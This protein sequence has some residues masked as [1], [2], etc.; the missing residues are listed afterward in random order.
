M[1][2][3]KLSKRT[4]L[5][6]FAFVMMLNA[7]LAIF[8]LRTVLAQTSDKKFR[9]QPPI[10]AEVVRQDDSPLTVT[11]INVDNTAES[12]QTVNYAA[13]N[14]GLKKI[15]AYV[16]LYADESGV[17]GAS[18]KFFQAFSSGQTIQSS[19]SKGRLNIETNSK[20][21]LS[22]DYIEFEDGSSWGKNSQSQSDYIGGYN[23]GQKGAVKEI[24]ELLTNTNKNAVSDLLQRQVTDTNPS[25]VNN[26]KPD[27]WQ[28]GFVSGY[29]SVLARL[30]IVY[31]NNG[32]EAIA[33]KIEQI[34]K[35]T[36]KEEN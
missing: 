2:N 13:Q 17:G 34:E 36:Q 25:S 7:F 21:F 32:L 3:I 10:T 22:L 29:R 35:L 30:Q 11:I 1:K 18:I 9:K 23:E 14:T 31:E 20:I 27:K 33:P 12:D 6:A 5:V 16:L 4:Y 28:Y 19:I 15:K 26:N 8:L 24:R